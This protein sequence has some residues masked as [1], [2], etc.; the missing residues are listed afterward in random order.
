MAIDDGCDT[1]TLRGGGSVGSGSMTGDQVRNAMFASFG[2]MRYRAEDVDYLLSRVAAELDAG[3]PVA[4]LI[5]NA[6]FR[7][8][9]AAAASY[10]AEAVSWYLG[11]V[12]RRSDGPDPAAG[13]AD[14]WCDLAVV[15][16]FT[17]AEADTSTTAWAS[18]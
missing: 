11:D 12:L 3:R 18:P 16:Q 7:G 15:N 14:P 1:E 4:A 13:S 9:F 5:N 17:R 2:L 10:E 6:H 8:R